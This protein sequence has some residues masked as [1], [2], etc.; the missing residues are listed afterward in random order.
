MIASASH[1]SPDSQTRSARYPL[2]GAAALL[3]SLACIALLASGAWR[4]P[5][6]TLFHFPCPA[7]GSTRATLSLFHADFKGVLLNPF[8][9]LMS[10][11]LGLILARAVWL[12]LTEGNVHRLG[13]GFGAKL[14]RA[15]LIIG[16]CEAV[17]WS[18]R[19]LGMFGGP[20]PI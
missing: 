3:V 5:T 20:V 17:L 4:C 8:A 18:C 13:D 1:T 7:C 19:W 2:R 12:E 11:T 9:P 6:A 15:I 10:L 14:T 16:V